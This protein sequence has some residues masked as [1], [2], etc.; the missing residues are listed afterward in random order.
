[1][2]WV[3]IILVYAKAAN[4]TEALA[5]SNVPGYSSKELCEQAAVALNISGNLPKG[6]PVP[7][8]YCIPG[9]K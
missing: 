3:L 4:G 2:T 1:M 6:W 7:L 5:V 9:G 8:G